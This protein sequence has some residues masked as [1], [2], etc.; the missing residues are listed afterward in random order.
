MTNEADRPLVSVIITTRNEAAVI[1]AL[2]RSVRAQ[3]WKNLEVILVD[4]KST[5]QTCTLAK[6]YVDS[7]YQQGPE[8]SAQR[9]YGVRQARGKFVL[10]LDAD[11]ELPPGVVE[12]A[13]GL[14][15]TSGTRALCIPERSFGENYWA[16]CKAL[17]RDCY[18][19]LPEMSAARFFDRE[20]FLQ[21]GGFDET[22]HGPEDWDLS[23]RA[24]ELTTVGFVKSEIRHNEGRI[25]LRPQ[26]RKKFYYAR[27][28]RRYARKHPAM[29][30]R[31]ANMLLR[32]AFLRHWRGL[33]RDPFHAA[34]MFVLKFC[35]GIAGLAGVMAGRK[36]N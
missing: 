35:E 11:M 31:Q 23:Q 32:P 14:A 2:L 36:D 20:L 21:L 1:E 34:G 29:A 30:R 18:V 4:N 5:D 22:L 25:T 3:T 28:F 19:G 15:T 13:V 7:L 16:R 9:N 27:S 12:E 17:E 33:A 26:M 6:P 8:R 24:T 10:I